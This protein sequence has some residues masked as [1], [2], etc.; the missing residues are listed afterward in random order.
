MSYIVGQTCR[1][2]GCT[3]DSP[4]VIP[5]QLRE[6]IGSRFCGW[7]IPGSVCN[8]P[9]CLE[10]HYRDLVEFIEPTIVEVYRAQGRI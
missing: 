4:C 5:E 7:L 2:C 3:E 8:A 6:L 9:A 1:Y 10:R